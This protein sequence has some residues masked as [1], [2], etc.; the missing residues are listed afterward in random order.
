MH[1]ALMHT[2]SLAFVHG[3]GHHEP[4]SANNVDVRIVL[5]GWVS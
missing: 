2:L 4:E 1:I 5:A 3:K